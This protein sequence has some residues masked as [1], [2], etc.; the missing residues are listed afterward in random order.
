M[1]VKAAMSPR[2]AHEDG[3]GATEHIRSVSASDKGEEREGIWEQR[4]ARASAQRFPRW[5]AVTAYFNE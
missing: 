4:R 2:F 5:Q 3:L 1:I